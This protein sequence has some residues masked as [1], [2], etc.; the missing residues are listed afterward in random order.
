MCPAPNQ[1][2]DEVIEILPNAGRC[3]EPLG[4]GGS[5][6]DIAGQRKGSPS[7]RVAPTLEVGIVARVIADFALDLLQRFGPRK[8]WI[9][10][11]NLDQAPVS[12]AAMLSPIGQF[13]ASKPSDPA[14]KK[15]GPRAP[16]RCATRPDH[17]RVALTRRQSSFPGSGLAEGTAPISR[18]HWL[19]WRGVAELCFSPRY[20]IRPRENS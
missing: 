1:C 4:A 18:M 11:Q 9:A 7:A 19:G 5:A 8:F 3:R 12:V 20:G 13:E 2:A 15:A 10:S 14:K 17:R 16:L 6:A